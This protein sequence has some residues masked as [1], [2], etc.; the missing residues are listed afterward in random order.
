MKK[1]L[2]LTLAVV[3]VMFTSSLFAQK[4]GY[5]DTQNVFASMQETK[6]A[7]AQLETYAKD[8][9][10]QAEAIQVEYN[11][12]YQEYQTSASTM[13]DAVRQL[14]EKELTDLITR[15]QEFQQVAQQEL[16]TKEN[17]LTAPIYEKMQTAINEVAKAGGYA[18][19]LPVGALIYFDEATVKDIAPEVKTKLGVSATATPAQ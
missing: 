6:D 3:C 17:E 8:L 4:I 15:I 12:K 16:Q 13:T 19:I 11:N 7:Y 18:L 9:Q 5:I 1:V 14:K 10:A 2:K